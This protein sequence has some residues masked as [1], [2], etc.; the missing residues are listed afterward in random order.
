MDALS[1]HD[2]TNVRIKDRKDGETVVFRFHK[3]CWLLY[4]REFVKASWGILLDLA[5][6]K[7]Y[8]IY[9]LF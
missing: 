3:G 8:G 5:L 2:K 4:G 9:D 7:V 6:F 1:L